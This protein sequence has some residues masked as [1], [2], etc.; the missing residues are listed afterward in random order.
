[1]SVTSTSPSAPPVQSMTY[2][3]E[4]GHQEEGQPDVVNR[5]AAKTQDLYALLNN[6]AKPLNSGE[7]ID[8]LDRSGHAGYI[9]TYG[10]PCYGNPLCCLVDMVTCCYCFTGSFCCDPCCNPIPPNC[11]T[12]MFPY[13]YSVLHLVTGK[14]IRLDRCPY[15]F[16]NSP[17]YCFEKT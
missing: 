12:K 2:V 15:T 8:L 1:M 6:R 10:T 4:E 17:V 9:I 7:I 14:T 3:Q 13:R 5:V 16:K 11:W